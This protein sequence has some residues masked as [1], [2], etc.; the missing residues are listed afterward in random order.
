MK[1]A[2]IGTHGTGKT[3]LTYLLAAHAKKIGKNARVINETAR[4]CPFPLNEGFSIDGARWII[5]TQIQKELSAK[6]AKTELLI[7]DR[8]S[9]DP[10]MYLD[11]GSFKQDAYEDLRQFA[12]SW[13]QTYDLLIWI[14]PDTKTLFHDGVRSTNTEF[15]EKVH[16]AFCKWMQKNTCDRAIISIDSSLVFDDK[17][18]NLMKQVFEC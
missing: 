16:E 6:A 12:E 15:Q 1:I 11:G 9:I 18:N 5:T 2:V 17:L 14:T 10:I 13:M 4:S 7:C 3:T 8:A